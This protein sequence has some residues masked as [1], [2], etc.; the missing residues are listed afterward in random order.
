LDFFFFMQ[1]KNR[2]FTLTA[3]ICLFVLPGCYKNSTPRPKSYPRIEFPAK[4]YRQYR[5]D[6]PYTFDFPV[7][8]TIEPEGDKDSSLCWFNIVYQPFNARLHLSYKPVHNEKELMG[9]TE[10]EHV[11]V[12]KHTVK[13][14]EI[15][16]DLIRTDNNVYGIY[17][18]LAGNTATALEFYV[19]DSTK[20]FLRGALYF[21]TRINRDSLDPMIEFLK[22][23]V[24]KMI[25]TLKWRN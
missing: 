22:T 21:K 1:I 7:Y 18:E 2:I 8:A 6:C 11:L 19:T 15:S 14:E 24:Q 23:D 12:Y 3:I 9:Y 16:E 13:A 4:T 17:Y 5:G 10:D 25:N 20:H